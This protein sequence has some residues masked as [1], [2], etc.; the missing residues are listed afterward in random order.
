M[1]G[2]SRFQDILGHDKNIKKLWHM[3]KED[4]LAH[5][6]LFSGP[7]GIGKK[8]VARLLAMALLCGQ[9]EAPCGDCTSC[10]AFLSGTHPDYQECAPESRGKSAPV[11]RID[12]VRDIEKKI[13]KKPLLSARFVVFI[14]DAEMMNEAAANSLLKILE[15][16]SGE[17]FFLLVTKKRAALLPTIL[18]RVRDMYFAALSKEV[19]ER[20]LLA[21]GIEKEKIQ[22]LAAAADGSVRTALF[23]Q[24]TDGLKLV[25]DA[26]NTLAFIKTFTVSRLLEK[27]A[28]LGEMP[29]ERSEK[30][31][32]AYARLLRDL[33]VIYAGG[34]TLFHEE[35]RP[36]LLN[37]LVNFSKEQIFSCLFLVQEALKRLQSNANQRLIFE[38]LLLRLYD[39]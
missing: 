18:S 28:E 25:E 34:G 33:L 38:G 1:G 2:F 15:E 11:I 26:M 3:L 4:R 27:A 21:R 19:I 6:L 31:L 7:A 10:R 37:V 17:V 32:C 13:A 8:Q 39:V 30:W 9:K 22:E 23:L 5:A 20:I 12:A 14:D 29:R 24:E 16:P 35:R 36:K